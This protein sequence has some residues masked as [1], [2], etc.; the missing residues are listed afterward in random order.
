M[1]CHLRLA[2]TGATNPLVFGAA[3]WQAVGRALPQP[4]DRPGTLPHQLGVE[5]DGGHTAWPSSR[6]MMRARVP[7]VLSLLVAKENA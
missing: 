7:S 4:I 1:V 5:R 3:R 6:P 2:S